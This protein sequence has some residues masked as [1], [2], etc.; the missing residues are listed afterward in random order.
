MKN[1]YNVVIDKIDRSETLRYLSHRSAP[2]E[3]FTVILDRCE[4]RLLAAIKGSCRFTYRI[5]TVKSCSDGCVSFPDCVMTLTGKDICE[6]LDG[7]GEAALLCATIG[8]AAD[9]LIRKL[10]LTDMAEAVITDAMAG[11]A[12]EYVCNEAEKAIIGSCPDRN[13]TWRFSPGYGDLPIELQEQF[14]STVGAQ[15]SIGLYATESCM[16]TP[17]KSVTAIIGL[18]HSPIEKKR[19]GCSVCNLRGDCLYRKNGAR[20]TDWQGV[21]HKN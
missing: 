3:K 2:D 12:I 19:R 13:I 16:L 15:K 7:C 9:A 8:S 1:T 10:Q 11:C 5:L 14:L 6:H 20:C 18:S 17:L 21:L 4:K